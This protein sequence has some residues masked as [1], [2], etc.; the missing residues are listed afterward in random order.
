[1][2]TQRLEF[3]VRVRKL[4][5]ISVKICYRSVWNHPFFLGLV[6]FLM[7]LYTSFPLLFSALVTASPVLVCTAVLLGTL[8]S[9]GSPYIP[10]INE[11][12]EEEKASH[13]IPELKTRATEHNTVVERYVGGD[14]F[15]EERHVG[16][17]WGIVKNAE[18]KVNWYNEVGEVEED[19]GSVHYKLLVDDDLDSRDIHCE[20]GVIDE[21]EGSLNDSLVE[22]KREIQEEILGSEGQLSMVQASDDHHV[23]TDIVGD[24]NLEVEDCKLREDLSDEQRDDEFD[25]LV[26]SWKYAVDNEDD[27]DDESL[28]FGSDGAESS[29][30]DASM[31]DIIPMLDEV[32]PLL[33]S[34]A[35]Q[36]AQFSDNGSDAIS[37]RSHDS[38]NDEIVESDE[39]ENQREEDDDDDDE[40]DAGDGA[41]EDK[42]DESKSAIKWTE[43]DQKN[44]M[45]LGTSEL[46]RNQRLDNLIARRR[47]RKNMRLMIEK[48]LMDVNSANIP[49]NITPIST[50]RHN[51]FEFPYDS[52]ADL[53]LPPFPASAPTILQPR[54]NPF[55]LPY[56]SS[57][58]K[59]DLKGDSFQEEFAGFN[60][61]ETVPQRE[62][63]LRRHESFNVGPA[64]LGFPQQELKWKPYFVPEH[65]VT[66]G[67]S[68]SSFHRQSSEVS[69][70]KLSSVPDTESVSSVVDE[71]DKSYEQDISQETELVTNEDHVSFHDEQ[72][73]ISSGDVELAGVDQV[74][75]R[76]VHL[77]VVGIT[78]GDG[79]SQMETESDFPEAG[80]TAHVQFNMTETESN[81]SEAGATTHVE[82]N[83]SDIYPR[84]GPVD[85]DFSSRFILSS[86][87]E[88][89]EKISDLT[90]VGAA[91][92]EP[93]G[94]E[95]KESSISIQPSFEESEFHF[96]TRVVDD[97][98]HSEPVYD[99]S[100]SVEK[101]LSFSS[102][103]S[104]AQTETS[105]M[106]AP[107]MF[108]ES[109]DKEPEGHGE[110]R[111]QGTS[112][113]QEMHAASLDLFENEP[114]VRDLPEIS[115][116]DGIYAG[117][118]GFSST[119][120]DHNVS[121]VPKSV[122]EYV[123]TDAGS[124]SS[125]E[126]LE[127]SF[128]KKEDSFIQNQEDLLSLGAEMS[129]AAE[130]G[131]GKILDCL[132][133][134][135]QHLMNP[136][137][138]S[139][140]APGDWHAVVK[141]DTLLEL[142][143]IHSSSSSEHNLVGGGARPKEEIIQTECCQMHLSNLDASLDVEAHHDKGEE[144]S[145]TA[146]THQAMPY[147]D[148]SSSTEDEYYHITVAQVNPSKANLREV[149][150]TDNE[151]GQVQ[152]IYSDSKIDCDV[153]HDMNLE[154]IPFNSSYQALPSRENPPALEKQLMLS[155]STDEPSID[156]HDKLEEP[157]II[158]MESTLELDFGN[159]DV[160]LLKIPGSEDKLS[161]N[162]TCMTSESTFPAES[163]EHSLPTDRDLKEQILNEME[164]E[165]SP[166]DLSEHF[167]HAAEIYEEDKQIKEINEI[168][169]SE[170][171]T[172]GDF[173]LRKTD[174]PEGS[175]IANTESAVLPED[176]KTKAN[177][178]QPVLEARSVEDIDLAFKQLYEG[179]DVDEVIH[180]SM[181][182]DPQDQADT[183]PKLPVVEVRSLEDTCKAF[184][185]SPE[186]NSAE[187]PY[188]S[189]I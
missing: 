153:D 3:G 145:S 118:S 43:D 158:A 112:S 183:N 81:F 135:Q 143:E 19:D 41:K 167:N 76:G 169:L 121:P 4:M 170:L 9:F 175:H 72:E 94:H 83:P 176:T 49:L 126:G 154:G 188:S 27:G 160:D 44:L 60:Q 29:S 75:N 159:N 25:S 136:V 47:A 91:G 26:F 80:A 182:E 161:A 103:S 155:K 92:F 53:G 84:T 77:A 57:E 130:Q 97:N 38:N 128:S 88:I 180:P 32:D 71:E 146:L 48:N 107:S 51:P 189:D 156:E 171:D 31:A 95:I 114:R 16:E 50:T 133:E 30:P 149:L 111:E 119:F 74:E 139:E 18:E 185:Q 23:L 59:P 172:I 70:S 125:D 141:E 131:M 62:A 10:E 100:P 85:E 82:L 177:V 124:S 13:H 132:P 67:S 113:F 79:E 129:L 42:E 187:L 24:R 89:D 147:N 8:L 148:E 56:D 39:L 166:Q 54:R 45:D 120:S 12:E 2:G 17:R 15:V 78:F 1:M 61:R 168:I 22:K 7:L 123:S 35:P 58:E 69:E 101:I 106:G 116:H 117:S 165:G 5:V 157:S 181:I 151:I 163:P 52:Y 105:E 184:Q 73:S 40:K 21:V 162:Y 68:S 99:S 173:N 122:V 179:I 36:P 108:V 186:S 98:Q 14:D 6:C 152:P 134:E 37:K 104:E 46:E 90:G 33:G 34:G 11:K 115:V 63:F 178:D 164:S 144:L 102:V 86:L 150:K 127:D 110:T 66:E 87:S 174:L 64:S 109:I 137:E 138:F 142:Y 140:A 28:D 55:D 96:T 65:L 20:N 93:R